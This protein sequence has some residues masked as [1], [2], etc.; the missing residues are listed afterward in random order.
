MFEVLKYDN[1]I[2]GNWSCI[3]EVPV[4]FSPNNIVVEFDGANSNN[5][6]D[7]FNRIHIPREL[8]NKMNYN[9]ILIEHLK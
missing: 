8:E 3:L 4:K 1:L 2:T 6:D 7:Y 9:S 5:P